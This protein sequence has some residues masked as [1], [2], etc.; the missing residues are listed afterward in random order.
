[1]A[2]RLLTQTAKRAAWA[3]RCHPDGLHRY[4]FG[5]G[6]A[7]IRPELFPALVALS[8]ILRAHDRAP[9][10]HDTWSYACRFIAGTRTWSTHAYGI[11]VDVRATSYPLGVRVRDVAL[12]A[13]AAE[14]EAL[15]TPDGWRVWEWGGRWNRPD[16][17]HWE[18]ACPPSS[19]RLLKVPI[20]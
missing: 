19:A 11:S 15:T 14:V 4:T 13:A 6:A 16:G 10:A 3:P 12:L 1:M 2:G 8:R 5:A 7:T 17:M 20:S 9:R 18:I